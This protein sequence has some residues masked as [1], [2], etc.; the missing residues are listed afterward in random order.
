MTKLYDELHDQ[1]FL[2]HAFPCNQFGGQE[3]GTHEEIKQFVRERY[4]GQFDLF[5]KIK[6]N[7]ANTHPIYEWLKKSFPGDLSWNFAG[8]FIINKQGIPV[9]RFQWEEWDVIRARIVEELNAPDPADGAAAAS[10]AAAPAASAEQ[11]RCSGAAFDAID[12][13][14]RP[15]LFFFV[16]CFYHFLDCIDGLLCFIFLFF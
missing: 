6:V 7:G 16:F 13:G 15:C 8:K 2:I 14:T 4:N 1:G 3:P 11:K 10:A 5:S 12:V 9:A